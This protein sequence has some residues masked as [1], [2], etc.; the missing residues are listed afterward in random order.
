MVRRIRAGARLGANVS[1]PIWPAVRHGTA[2]RCC[3]RRRDRRPII[4]DLTVSRMGRRRLPWVAVAA[5]FSEPQPQ[6]QPGGR[7]SL[8]LGSIRSMMGGQSPKLR[9]YR[10]WRQATGQTPWSDQS[11]SGLAREAGITTSVHSGRGAD[12]NSARGMSIRHRT[13]TITTT[14][15][16]IPTTLTETEAATTRDA[17]R[18][19]RDTKKNGRTD[20]AAVFDFQAASSSFP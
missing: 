14:P 2:A 18:P 12:D 9:R 7:G 11:G 6:P 5:H 3:S 13:M 8:L 20:R 15:I 19:Q 1:R 17:F 4:R 10:G 16:S